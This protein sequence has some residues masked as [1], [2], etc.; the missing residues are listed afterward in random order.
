[1]KMFLGG[2]FVN[3]NEVQPK[4]LDAVYK[5]KEVINYSIVISK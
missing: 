4:V 1:M 3:K 5:E 2:V